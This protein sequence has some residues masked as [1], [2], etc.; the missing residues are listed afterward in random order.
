MN[1]KRFVE[2]FSAYTGAIAAIPFSGLIRSSN[3]NYLSGHSPENSKELS[4]DLVVCGG[5]LGGCAATLAALRN[6]LT[7]VLTEETDWIGGQISQQ[8]VPPDE[9]QWIETHG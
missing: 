4:A 1:R 8:G 2:I 7:V 9:H 5:G 3:P 6:N